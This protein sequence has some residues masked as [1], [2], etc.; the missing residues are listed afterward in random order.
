MAALYGVP[1]NPL[2]SDVV[3][4]ASAAFTVRVTGPLV[5]VTGLPESVTFTVTVTGPAVVGVPLMTQPA[6][7]SVRPAGNV[8]LVSVQ[9]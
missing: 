2:G 9:E 6:L 3:V 5:V 7:V 8:P 4:S 1:T